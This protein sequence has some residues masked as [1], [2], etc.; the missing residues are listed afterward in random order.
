MPASTAAGSTL[1]LT[2]NGLAGTVIPLQFYALAPAFFQVGASG[3]ATATHT[4]GTL[5]GPVGL[6]TSSTT[7]A[8]AGEIITIYGN[9]FGATNPA[10]PDGNLVSAPLTLITPPTITIAGAPAQVVYAGLT[11]PGLYQFNVVVP[12]VDPGNVST[13]A[14]IGSVVTPATMI[15]IQ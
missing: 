9:G 7:P 4:D 5:I 11:A 6:F 1:Q 3:F 15:A 2:N 14:Q 10:Q 8:R 12:Q 13:I